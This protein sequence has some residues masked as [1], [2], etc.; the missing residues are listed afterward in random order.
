M[1]NMI[2][3]I[4]SIVLAAIVVALNVMV[5]IHGSAMNA[6]AGWAGV[7]ILAA[8]LAVGLAV[9]E[10]KGGWSAYKSWSS[11]RRAAKERVDQAREALRSAK[12]ARTSARTAVAADPGNSA[13]Q[14]AY[15]N[16]RAA[17][18]AARD[19]LEEAEDE[20]SDL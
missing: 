5:W 19:A 4:A 12:Q 3:A 2:K 18:E 9:C 20:L 7:A 15:Q 6:A 10:I 17:V 1:K 8:I 16:A 14:A 11:T 13:L